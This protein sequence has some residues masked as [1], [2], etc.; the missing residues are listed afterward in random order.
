M[1]R[2][3]AGSSSST[4]DLEEGTALK[5]DFEKLQDIVKGESDV[6]PVAVQDSDTKEVLIVAYVNDEALAYTLSHGVA[7]F[8]STSRNE[9]WVK[10]A[11][12]GDK[13]ELVDV[14]VNCEQNSLLYLV[15]PLGAGAC[16]TRG[17]DGNARS[18]CFYRRIDRGDSAE[19]GPV[20]RSSR[21]WRLTF[22]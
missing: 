15:R 5:L 4:A 13:L 10:G 21:S 1:N 14:R 16:H 6:I 11:T 19:D 12:S 22:V 9:L 17:A 18:G 7:A 8:W 20:D 2:I 3:D